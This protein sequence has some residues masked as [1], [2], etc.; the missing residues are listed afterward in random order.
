ME[1]DIKTLKYGFSMDKIST[2]EKAVKTRKVCIHG[3]FIVCLNSVNT[4]QNELD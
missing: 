1:N 2:Q 3:H 4:K